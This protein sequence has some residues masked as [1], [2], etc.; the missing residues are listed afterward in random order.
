MPPFLHPAFQRTPSKNA[1]AIP[2]KSTGS[3]GEEY[4]VERRW[5]RDL[6]RDFPHALNKDGLGAKCLLDSKQISLVEAGGYS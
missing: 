2:D 4:S 6:A 1:M 3:T 5:N